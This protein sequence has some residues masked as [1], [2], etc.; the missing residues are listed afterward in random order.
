[1]PTEDQPIERKKAFTLRP[2]GRVG[3]PRIER[4]NRS[5]DCDLSEAPDAEWNKAIEDYD[6]LLPVP[7]FIR[8]TVR[9]ATLT[10]EFADTKQLAYDLTVAIDKR[11]SAANIRTGRSN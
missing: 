7:F 10:A 9:D 6:S 5:V 4:A 3:D 11:I 2:I 1:M 8:I